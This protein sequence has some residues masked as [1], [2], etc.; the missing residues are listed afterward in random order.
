MKKFIA[1][2]LLLCIFVL[3]GCN[4]EVP[5]TKET[6]DNTITAQ[7]IIIGCPIIKWTPPKTLLTLI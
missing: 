7:A 1:I 6:S 5:D 2:A 3:S 4:T